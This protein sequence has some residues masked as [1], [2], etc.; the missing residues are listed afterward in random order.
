M[1]VK[2]N[3]PFYMRFLSRLPDE[4]LTKEMEFYRLRGL[5]PL[6]RLAISEKARRNRKTRI[7]LSHNWTPDEIEVLEEFS[8]HP[9]MTIMEVK[10][11]LPGRSENAIRKKMSRLGLSRPIWGGLSEEDEELALTVWPGEPAEVT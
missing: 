10:A 7:D 5:K 1:E 4:G 6:Y 11:R 8:T 2:L 3:I 9:T